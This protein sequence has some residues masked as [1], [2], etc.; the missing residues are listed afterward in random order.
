MPDYD[1]RK[2]RDDLLDTL[3]RDGLAEDA[4]TSEAVEAAYRQLAR[5]RSLLLALSL[6]DAV[7]EERRPNVPGTVERDNWRIPLPVP[8]D[9]LESS[10][11][12]SRLVRLVTGAL[13]GGGQPGGL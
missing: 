10:P 8:V 12:V 7:L 5:A 9:A 6:E 13:A 2:G 3:G 1:V 4:P 11:E